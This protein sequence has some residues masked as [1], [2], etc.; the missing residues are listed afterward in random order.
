MRRDYTEDDFLKMVYATP[1][2][3]VPGAKWRYSNLAYLTLGVM[4]HRLTGTFY[5]DLLQERIFRPL[6]MT[7]ARVI[8][9]SDI[10]PN[11]A[12]GYVMKQGKLANQDWVSPSLNTTA[13]GALYFTVLDLAKWDAA[14]YTERLLKKSSL[15]QMWT[16]IRLN[17]GSTHPYGFGW[18]VTQAN[19]HR[20]IEHSGG[21]QGFVTHIARYPDDRLTVVL[22][23]NLGA[24]QTKPAEIAHRVA[25]FYLPALLPATP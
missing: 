10:V 3:F 23:T 6:G 14:L 2:E 15:D 1:L 21:W 17:D 11:R 22:L 5:G 20:L 24:Q 7:T 18:G 9:E 25:A 4:I 16:P 8:S 13:D 12:A 19:G